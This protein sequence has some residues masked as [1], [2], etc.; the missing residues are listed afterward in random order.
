MF[1]VPLF[2][3]CGDDTEK[4]KAVADPDCVASLT[5]SFPDG[6]ETTLDYCQEFEFSVAFEFDPDAAPEIREPQLKFWA[7]TDTAFNCWVAISEPAACGD[8]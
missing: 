6:T 7:T 8:G 4:K 1:A 5:L 2:V 3:G